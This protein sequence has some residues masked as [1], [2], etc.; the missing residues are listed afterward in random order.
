MTENYD[1]LSLPCV[2]GVKAAEAVRRLEATPSSTTTQRRWS[3][4]CADE[5][6]SE[7]ALL[8]VGVTGM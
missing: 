7:D 1:D 4:R 6:L 5:P 8:T 3:R 2:A